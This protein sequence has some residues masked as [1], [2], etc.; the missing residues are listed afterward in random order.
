MS[1]G[2]ERY[3]SDAFHEPG[4]RI[5]G[6]TAADAT[7]ADNIPI[8]PS[9]W[10]RSS[11]FWRYFRRRF[12]RRRRWI[13]GQTSG[14][15]RV[16][17]NAANGG[18]GK[19]SVLGVGVLLLSC[20]PVSAAGP[21]SSFRISSSCSGLVR[22]FSFH[23]P[24]PRASL[25]ARDKRFVCID[26]PPRSLIVQSP[27]FSTTQRMSRC[28]LSIDRD[29][30]YERTDEGIADEAFTWLTNTFNPLPDDLIPNSRVI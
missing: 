19:G 13:S 26:R 24:R 4:S 16:R 3:F 5:A 6:G 25:C 28:L 11:L 8:K 17:W 20:H 2:H 7:S 27:R 29:D 22:F 1:I 21:L 23:S 18:Q 9:S 10:S 30:V 14:N 12:R 15:P